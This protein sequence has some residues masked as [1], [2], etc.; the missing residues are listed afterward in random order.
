MLKSIATCIKL[1]HN[2]HQMTARFDSKDRVFC[3]KLQRIMT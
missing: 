3:V 1:P 2:L